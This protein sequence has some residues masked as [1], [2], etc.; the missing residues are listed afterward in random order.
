MGVVEDVLKLLGLVFVCVTVQKLTPTCEHHQS[1][2]HSL[3]GRFQQACDF[4]GISFDNTLRL[5]FCGSQ[6]IPIQEISP[7]DLPKIL[8][9]IA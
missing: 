9:A 5:S 6:P 8:R 4:L 3:A 2:P 7:F 1:L